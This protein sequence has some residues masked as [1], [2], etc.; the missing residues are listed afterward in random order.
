MRIQIQRAPFAQN[1]AA[2]PKE[3][4]VTLPE[5]PGSVEFRTELLEGAWLDEFGVSEL[6]GVSAQRL[7]D[8]RA[9]RSILAVWAPDPGCYRY[10]VCQFDGKTLVPR[11]GEILAC[12]PRGNGSG[13]SEVMW[14]YTPKALLGDQAPSELLLSDPARVLEAAVAERDGVSSW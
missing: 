8:L 6:L 4:P 10:P 5:T 1:R 3:D 2:L 7:R 13:W 14:L 9:E 11:L 12:L